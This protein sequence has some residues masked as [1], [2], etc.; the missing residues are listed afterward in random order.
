M[1]YTDTMYGEQQCYG[2]LIMTLQS[3]KTLS[4]YVYI[5]LSQCL[6]SCAFETSQLLYFNPYYFIYL[7][8]HKHSGKENCANP[9]HNS[10]I[11]ENCVYIVHIYIY[12]YKNMVW[13]VVK[14]DTAMEHKAL[15]LVAKSGQNYF[16]LINCC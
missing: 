1:T 14:D 15:S 16:G 8:K 9:Q 7:L 11:S 6:N 5:M 4:M 10:L 13:K 12:R 2:V 3:Q